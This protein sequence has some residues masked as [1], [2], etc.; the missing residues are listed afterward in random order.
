[1][2]GYEVSGS[3]PAGGNAFSRWL[4]RTVL[5]LAGWRIEGALPDAPKIMVVGAPHTSNWDFLY[6]MAVMFA[7]GIH[8]SWMAKHTLFWP[9]LGWILRHFGGVATN[10]S[11]AHGAVEEIAGAFRERE[12]LVI[13]VTPEGTRSPVTEWKTG[14]YRIAERAQVPMALASWDYEKKVF[15]LGPSFLPSGDMEADMERVKAYYRQF[16]GKYEQTIP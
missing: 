14:F 12:Q 11:A 6:G 1:M 16:R 9:P 3:I 4:G 7:I 2:S 13:G 15:T 8:A 10:R 5:R